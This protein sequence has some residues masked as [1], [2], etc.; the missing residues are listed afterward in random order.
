MGVFIATTAGTDDVAPEMTVPE[1]ATIAAGDA[2]DAM[3]DVSATDNVEGDLTGSV[4]VITDL[5]TTIPGVYG[6][7][8]M[9]EDST[10]NQA[11]AT[12]AVIV[13]EAAGDSTPGGDQTGGDDHSG[14]DTDGDDTAADAD[15][16][17]APARSV[18]QIMVAL[19]LR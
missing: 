4:H 2:F 18:A 7:T 13:T 5:D 10:G 16:A 15:P 19:P 3:T 12:R 9:V 17:A 1:V 6:L 11:T 14:Q 8:Y